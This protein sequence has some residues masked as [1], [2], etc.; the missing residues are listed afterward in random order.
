M[1]FG[2]VE[3]LEWAH[4][5]PAVKYN[6]SGSAVEETL[7]EEIDFR[8][9]GLRFSGPNQYGYLPLLEEIANYYQVRPSNVTT[10]CGTSMANFLVCAA[11]LERGDEVIVEKP[12]YG[13]LLD[14]PLALGARVKRL[15]RRFEAGYQIDLRELKRVAS[16]RT[17]LL[18][19]TNLHNPSG[20]QIA[21]DGLEE[22][23]EMARSLKFHVLID[24][25][26][27]TDPWMIDQWNEH[28]DTWEAWY[29]NG[30]VFTG[31][32]RRGLDVLTFA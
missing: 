29:Y 19:L 30:Y 18:V 12:C 23:G 20:I 7:A 24:F 17:K 15:E 32:L 9:E 16:L 28:T 14:L 4:L 22:I 1:S 3:Y 8:W 27:P 5:K 13:P 21:K 31:D 2:T 10:A 6:L 26:D 11:L 25:T